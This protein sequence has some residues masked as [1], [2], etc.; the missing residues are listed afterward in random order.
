MKGG[1]FVG[2]YRGLVG[3]IQHPS[4]M[5]LEDNIGGGQRPWGGEDKGESSK[6]VGGE[7]ADVR[8]RDRWSRHHI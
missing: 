3:E 7:Y 2:Q 6:E 4:N 1:E 5:T 8:E